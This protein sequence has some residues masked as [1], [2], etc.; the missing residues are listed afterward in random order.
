MKRLNETNYSRIDALEAQMVAINSKVDG[1]A[2]LLTSLVKRSESS[3]SRD[4]AHGMNFPLS[5]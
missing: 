1:M 4:Y 2:E 5:S 3:A